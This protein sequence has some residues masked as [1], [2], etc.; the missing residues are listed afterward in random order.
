[1]PYML[2]T[3]PFVDKFF[4]QINPGSHRESFIEKL[5]MIT[6]IALSLMYWEIAYLI[7]RKTS[8]KNQAGISHAETSATGC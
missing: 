6:I 7:G 4:A 3:I 1:M 5:I 2:C 8:D